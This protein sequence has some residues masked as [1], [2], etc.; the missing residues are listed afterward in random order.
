MKPHEWICVSNLKLS[1]HIL[2]DC[3]HTGTKPE[4]YL[5]CCCVTPVAIRPLNIRT[6]YHNACEKP[7]LIFPWILLKTGAVQK[8]KARSE[9]QDVV[10]QRI[11]GTFYGGSD[12]I[13]AK[14]A[15]SCML[16]RCNRQMY[17]TAEPVKKSVILRILSVNNDT[18]CW[19]WYSY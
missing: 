3:N 9:N 11:N 17:N 18:T 19:Y 16:N 10:R 6:Y 8:H 15:N 14:F 7:R 1:P 4:R 13:P 12:F 2:P 5:R